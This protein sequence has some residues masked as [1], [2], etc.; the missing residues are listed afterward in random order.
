M[1]TEGGA[2]ERQQGRIILG[3]CALQ[4]PTGI[5][6]RIVPTRNPHSTG[7]SHVIQ[8]VDGRV[9]RTI[10][11]MAGDDAVPGPRPARRGELRVCSC[12]AGMGI[13]LRARGPVYTRTAGGREEVVYR[14]QEMDEGRLYAVEWNGG[15]YA[16]RKSGPDVEIFK[17]RPDDGV[18]DGGACEGGDGVRKSGH[19]RQRPLHGA[20]ALGAFG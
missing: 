18:E 1:S 7:S 17:F 6:L 11:P 20:P 19:A 15:H 5:G 2:E 14:S 10:A 4:T 13:A 8:V 9:A 16:L 12:G 3:E